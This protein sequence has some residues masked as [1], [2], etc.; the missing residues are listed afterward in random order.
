VERI[1][2][3]VADLS[4]SVAEQSSKSD[5]TLQALGDSFRT[6]LDDFSDEY[7]QLGLDEVVVGAIAQVVGTARPKS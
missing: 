2:A 7:L 6:L 4:K 3:V 1:Q 5:P